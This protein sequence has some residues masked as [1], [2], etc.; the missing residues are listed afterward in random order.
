[1]AQGGSASGYSQSVLNDD[2]CGYWRLGESMLPVAS[3]SSG[4]GSHGT[5]I[6]G[7]TLE[8]PGAVVGDA[9][10]AASFDGAGQ[11]K[12]EILAD[13]EFIGTQEF[14]VELWVNPPA[15]TTGYPTLI[16]QFDDLTTVKNGWWI[17]AKLDST[18]F[19]REDGMGKDAAQGP[20]L[21]T[22]AFTHLVATYDSSIMRLFLNARVIG[23]KAS[24]REIGR[25]DRPLVIAGRY[26]NAD[27]FA[28]TIDEVAIYCRALTPQEVLDHYLAATMP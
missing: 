25:H 27:P 1:M 5:Y 14:S 13:Y 10:T 4:V 22:D 7:V 3:D 20:P 15:L 18:I 21:A 17:H 11:T 8:A 23:E 6:A 16:G 19:W 9:D 26:T 28:G 24:I 12:L 2:P